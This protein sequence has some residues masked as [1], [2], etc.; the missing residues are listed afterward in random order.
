MKSRGIA[1]VVAVFALSA[2]VY[3]AAPAQAAPDPT[4][5]AAP[6][7]S[8]RAVLKRSV[9]NLSK[10]SDYQVLQ[11]LLAAQGPVADKHPELKQLLGFDPKKPHTDERALAAVIKGYLKY[12][13]N[14]HTETSLPL[15]SGN[16]QAVEA[17]LRTFST[18]FT[19]FVQYSTK[20]HQATASKAEME[21]YRETTAQANGRGWLWMGAYVA[22]Y[23]NAAAVANA[24]VY[25]NAAVATFALATLA[26]VVWYLEDES[27]SGTSFEKE[28]FVKTM[29]D[30]FA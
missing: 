4:T 6:D 18:S 3:G 19:N 22:V 25:A 13:P 9:Q 10:Y 21:K 8:G 20:K 12:N 29:T 15:Q 17:G 16:P 11:L 7:A 27:P 5:T 14:F 30:A 24:V 28:H 23:A 2:G 1:A 26:V